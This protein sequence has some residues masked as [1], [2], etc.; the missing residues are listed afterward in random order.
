LA[1]GI[2]GSPDPLVC[3]ACEPPHHNCE[4]RACEVTRRAD[5]TFEIT[6]LEEPAAS[7]L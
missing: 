7:R 5:G 6:P 1:H 4:V 2:F 3:C